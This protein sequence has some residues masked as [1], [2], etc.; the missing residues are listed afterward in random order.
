MIEKR[1]RSVVN[2][3][4]PVASFRELH[5]PVASFR[6]SYLL[7]TLFYVITVDLYR[8]LVLFTFLAGVISPPVFA[9]R[10]IRK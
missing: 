3:I 9:M 7:F 8:S 10:L 1:G 5:H 2:C 6:E 4:I